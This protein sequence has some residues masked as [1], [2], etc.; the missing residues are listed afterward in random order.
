VLLYAKKM[1][2]EGDTL[3]YDYNAGGKGL[4]PTEEFI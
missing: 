2:N 4:F 1:I 3:Q